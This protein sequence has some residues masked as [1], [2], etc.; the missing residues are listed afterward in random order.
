MVK[1]NGRPQ[2]VYLTFRRISDKSDPMAWR[3]PGVR[4]RQVTE[5]VEENVR[6]DVLDLIRVGFE[7]DIARLGFRG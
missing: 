4:P 5:A 1:M 2:S 7:V 6:K 3:H